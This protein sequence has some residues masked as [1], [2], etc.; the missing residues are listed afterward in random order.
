M[1]MGPQTPLPPLTIL[2]AS[3]FT[4]SP[5]PAYLLATSLY[6]GPTSFFSTAWQAMQFL[7][8]ASA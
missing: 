6:D 2:A 3:L 8:V 5:W 4:A 7:A 1:G